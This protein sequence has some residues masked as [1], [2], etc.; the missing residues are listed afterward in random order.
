MCKTTLQMAAVQTTWS[1]VAG[2]MQTITLVNPAAPSSHR[3]ACSCPGMSRRA[4]ERRMPTSIS[5]GHCTSM[6]VG[7]CTTISM[8][9]CTSSKVPGS[10]TQVFWPAAQRPAP[11]AARASPATQNPKPRCRFWR[12][13]TPARDAAAT[14]SRAAVANSLSRRAIESVGI[15]PGTVRRRLRRLTPPKGWAGAPLAPQPDGVLPLG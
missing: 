2:D 8:G 14:T 12:M 10:C 6:S 5:M 11:S 3:S 9:H 4:F 13:P 7:H 15:V 1:G